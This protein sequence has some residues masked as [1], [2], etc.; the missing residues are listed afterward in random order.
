MIGVL[1]VARAVSGVSDVQLRLVVGDAPVDA[2]A[3]LEFR[4]DPASPSICGSWVARSAKSWAASAVERQVIL[5][6][7]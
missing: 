5:R 3:E 6:L 2:N 4:A 7:K 1:P